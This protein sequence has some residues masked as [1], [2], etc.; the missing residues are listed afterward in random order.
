[1]TTNIV[2]MARVAVAGM[3]L[4]GAAA[5]GQEADPAVPEAAPVAAGARG[6]DALEEAASRGA[7]EALAALKGGARDGL[8]PEAVEAAVLEAVL[9]AGD[10]GAGFD[11]PSAAKWECGMLLVGTEGLPRVAFVAEESAAAAAGIAAG[12]RIA[13]AG[14]VAVAPGADLS[15][16][17]A[18][19]GGGE[20]AA[21][22]VAVEPADG[23]ERKI[24]EIVRAARGDGVQAAVAERLPTGI[25]YVWM[26]WVGEGAADAFAKALETLGDVS[27]LVVDLRGAGGTAA[28]EIAGIAHRFTLPGK[29][30]YRIDEGT[31]GALT[32][33]AGAFGERF[34]RPAMVLV[35][36]GTTGAAE[37]EK[38]AQATQARRRGAGFMP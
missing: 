17:R 9:R 36:E 23:G 18:A 14:G 24:V 21:L 22:A 10:P 29:I 26:P 4:A 6:A 34:G 13:E 16:M 11:V 8:A 7:R 5:W 32:P 25:G 35:D 27:G 15:G 19:L 37:T 28:E 1:M 31:A 12:D 33:A 2:W 30:L 38:A 3:L 20:E